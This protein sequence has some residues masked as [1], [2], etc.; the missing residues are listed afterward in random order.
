MTMC[1][2]SEVNP[3]EDF[4][5]ASIRAIDNSAKQVQAIYQEY[6]VELSLDDCY[7]KL[8]ATVD[9]G[10]ENEYNPVFTADMTRRVAT[11]ANEKNLGMFSFW[12]INRDSMMQPN[13]AISTQYEHF[14]ASLAY[15]G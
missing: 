9:I 7:K 11:Y 13:R 14:D 8:G 10:Y 3:G 2:G 4:A 1:Y 15:L 5:E 6:G 12:S